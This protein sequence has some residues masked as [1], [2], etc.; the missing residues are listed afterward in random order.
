MD[1][2]LVVIIVF[3]P[4]SKIGLVHNTRNPDFTIKIMAAKISGGFLYS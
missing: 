3:L 2:G 1:D 4:I